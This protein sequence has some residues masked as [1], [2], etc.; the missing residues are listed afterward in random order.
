MEKFILGLDRSLGGIGTL[1]RE[2]LG[3]GLRSACKTDF[4]MTFS[5]N[6]IVNP[7]VAK[8]FRKRSRRE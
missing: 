6:F 7:R 8:V 3:L 2:H 4:F 1:L 5:R